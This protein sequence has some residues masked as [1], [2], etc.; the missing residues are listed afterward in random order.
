MGFEANCALNEACCLLIPPYCP[1]LGIKNFKDNHRKLFFMPIIC[2]CFRLFVTC[3]RS[4]NH[5]SV[6]PIGYFY[7]SCLHWGFFL[8]LWRITC[9][10][11]TDHFLWS[12]KWLRGYICN[13]TNWSEHII[14][15]SGILNRCIGHLLIQRSGM[16]LWVPQNLIWTSEL[17]LDACVFVCERSYWLL[18][19][20]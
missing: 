19:I 13:M 16:Q 20:A 1:S 18:P 5:K 14:M 2:L 10:P 6:I 12:S 3:N 11:L 17:V 4:F 15:K 8:Q 9:G 7:F